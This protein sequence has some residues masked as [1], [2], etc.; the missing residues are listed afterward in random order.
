MKKDIKPA[1]TSPSGIPTYTFK[2]ISGMVDANGEALDST[3]RFS[4]VMAQDLLQLAPNAL[5]QVHPDGYYSVDY[6]KIDVD[7][8]KLG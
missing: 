6:S 3:S 4:G 2:Y 7:F 8:E 5:L 1:G